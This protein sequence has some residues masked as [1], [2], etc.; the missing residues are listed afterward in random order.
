MSYGRTLSHGHAVGHVLWLYD[1]SCSYKAIFYLQRTCLLAIKH[2][3]SED[4][5]VG[6]WDNVFWL[7]DMSYGNETL[8][9]SHGI[10][11][12]A[13]RYVVWPDDIVLRPEE[14]SYGYAACLTANKI[15]Y[16][17]RIYLMAWPEDVVL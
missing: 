13:I 16:G 4:I 11:S 12:M 10:C 15:S 5:V 14:M 8:C 2:V 9:H 17:H 3:W 7:L 6:E 1:M